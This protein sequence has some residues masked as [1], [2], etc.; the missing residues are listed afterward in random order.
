[1]PLYAPFQLPDPATP[2][3]ERVA[4]QL[5]DELF[6][7]FTTVDENGM[8]QSLPVTFLWDDAQSTFLIY[9]RPEAARDRHIQHSPGVALHFDLSGGDII[10]ITGEAHFSDDPPSDQLPAWVQK[11]R[12]LYPRLGQTPKQYADAA[13]VP[14]RIRPLTL[15]HAPNPLR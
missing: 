2:A 14:L 4:R 5:H 12:D 13:P 9:N 7:W 3:G 10:I 1:M 6:I 15:R 8:P 11:Y